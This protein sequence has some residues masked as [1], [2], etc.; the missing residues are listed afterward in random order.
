M[1]ILKRIGEQEF[2]LVEVKSSTS[3]KPEHIPDTAIQLHVLEGS[4]L[5]V[6]RSYLMHINN[7]YVYQGGPQDLEQLFSLN[8][9]T[10]D[11]RA[12]ASVNAPDDLARMW[13]ILQQ[14]QVPA[15]ETGPHCTTPY[16]CPFYGNC[17]QNETGHPIGELP[18]L[19]K[20]VL[21]ELRGSGIGDIGSIP[22]DF[23]SLTP[24]QRRVRDCVVTEQPYIRP[25]LAFRLEEI[26]FPGSFL[27]FETFSSAIP[28]YVG[29]TPYQII[30]FQWSLHIRDSSSQLNHESFLNDD[31]E[32]PRERFVTSLLGALPADGTIVVYSGYEQAVIKQLAE[33]FPQYADHLLDLCDRIFDLMKLIRESYYHPKFHGSRTVRPSSSKVPFG[34][35]KGDLSGLC[36]GLG[37]QSYSRI[38]SQEPFQSLTNSLFAVDFLSWLRIETSPRLIKSQ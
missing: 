28:F 30:P 16:P 35:A 32:D 5:R 11:A 15:V 25:D 7:A 29:T 9:I 19:S 38:H 36:Q 12:F 24:T 27:D 3:V 2:D 31:A 21:E 6:R 18:R 10:D 20:K 26:K 13:E 23:P 22:A 8:D 4:G 17:H 37:I 34:G 14:D 1:D 33:A